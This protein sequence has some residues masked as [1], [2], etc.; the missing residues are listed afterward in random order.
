[1]SETLILALISMV[2]CLVLAVSGFASYRLN[3]GKTLQ[4]ALTWLAIFVG[5]FAVAQFAGLEL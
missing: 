1:M 4:M 2:G 5:A 3:W